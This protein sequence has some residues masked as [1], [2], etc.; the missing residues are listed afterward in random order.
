MPTSFDTHMMDAILDDAEDQVQEIA[1]NINEDKALIAVN[2]NIEVKRVYNE[3]ENLI[4]LGNGILKNAK[5]AVEMDPTAEGVLAGTASMMNAVKDTVKEFTKIHLQNLKFE[6]QV[7]LEKLKQNGREK[8]VELRKTDNEE[9]YENL[10][11]FN[12]E[13]IIK[14]IME[15]E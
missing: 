12:Q 8:I 7:Q 3:L 13:D 9:E 14:E 5:Y 15:N 10:V 4:S 11:P 2:E 1:K 6:Q